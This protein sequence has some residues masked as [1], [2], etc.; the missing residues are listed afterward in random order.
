[1]LNCNA[2]L[3]SQVRLCRKIEIHSLE[4]YKGPKARSQ[5]EK[6]IAINLDFFTLNDSC[7][8]TQ[9]EFL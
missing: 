6:P 8:D 5:S 1:M 4:S 9:A 3:L 2:G 7:F